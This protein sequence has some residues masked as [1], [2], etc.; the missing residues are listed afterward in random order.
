[1]KR[2]AVYLGAMLLL[3]GMACA[4]AE[5]PSSLG[6]SG[7]EIHAFKEGTRQLQLADVNGDGRQ[8]V[9]FVNNLAS[10]LEVLLRRDVERDRE[11]VLPKLDDV[12]ESK[13]LI[14]DQQVI[15]YRIVDLRPGEEGM[16][17]LAFGRTLGL[18]LFEIAG[19]GSIGD[20]R[21]LFLEGLE[22]VRGIDTGDLNGDGLGDIAVFREDGVVVLWNDVS[23]RA[24]GRRSALDLVGARCFWGD[25]LD[26]NDDAKLDLLFFMKPPGTPLVVRLGDGK[27]GFGLEL[28]L[29]YRTG[30][31]FRSI[32][33][34]DGDAAQLA[35]VLERGIGVRLYHYAAAR[36]AEMLSEDE[37]M[38]ARIAIRGAGKSAPC[39]VVADVDADGYEDLF[40][41]APELSRVMLFRGGEEGLQIPG[42]VMDTTADVV[43][44]SRL[45]S[46]DLLVVSRREKMAA[47]HRADDLK[48]FP[49]VIEA[50]G[51]VLAGGS[52]GRTL[53]L[54]T[55]NDDAE[56]YD[57]VVM[58]SAERPAEARRIEIPDLLNDPTEMQTC[59]LGEQGIGVL[60]YVP[61]AEPKMLILKDDALTALDASRFR[62]LSQSLTPGQVS[63][64]QGKG[65]L[66]ITVSSAQT[67]RTYGWNG[68]RFDVV[69]QLNPAD[70][71]ANLV[72][73][74]AFTDTD[75]TPGM[76]LLDRAGRNLLWFAEGESDPL[77]LH[78]KT[79]V[80]DVASII[81]LRSKQGRNL[82]M[83]G[84]D[85][86]HLLADTMQTLEL[87]A[88]A[89][90]VSPS[91]D[92]RLVMVRELDLGLPRL[93]MAFVD[94]ANGTLE[95]AQRLNG[96][97]AN[98]LTFKVFESSAFVSDRRGGQEP[99]GIGAGD[100]DGDGVAD[101][102]MLVHDRLLI[103][104][105]E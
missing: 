69:R 31:A 17:L 30:T 73:G 3:A 60:L 104:F 7:M 83:L 84:R 37:L 33:G 64:Q 56:R 46:G 81:A 79:D 16:D 20:V 51:D 42:E 65:G 61:Y 89:D 97:M 70:K 88:C 21:D 94:V 93:T 35:V 38:P 28:P 57:L 5:A 92:A 102:A 47:L 15:D 1:M 36:T 58:A 55:R 9:V 12:F 95:I 11:E 80:A 100:I 49:R 74:C 23:A 26:V 72:A 41:A 66:E 62:A 63:V 27:G 48:A 82:V 52:F 4:D 53:L 78:L 22:G 45:A 90:Y 76:L 98:L 103:Y 68:E 25:V 105:G 50:G 24:F 2:S 59:D 19:D 10:R 86:L 8:D 71:Q 54:V 39:Y 99:H 75:N 77:R 14:L 44:M 6:F 32:G 91:E 34:E 18:Q 85:S 67:A 43:A 13:G 29:D 40:V 101:L 96:G 87:K